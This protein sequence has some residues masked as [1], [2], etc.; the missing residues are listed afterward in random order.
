MSGRNA[1]RLSLPDSLQTKL[2]QFRRHVWTHKSIEAISIAVFVVFTVFLSVYFLD[3]VVDTPRQLRGALLLLA[4]LGCCIVPWSIYRWIWKCQRLDQLAMLL[5]HEHPS[6]GDQLLG[7]I[8]LVDNEQEQARSR[9]LCEAAVVQVAEQ[10]EARDLTN[11]VP[12]PRHKLLSKLAGGCMLAALVLLAVSPAATTNAWSRYLLPWRDTPR[13][14]FTVIDPQENERT[15]PHGENFRF[16]IRLADESRWRPGAAAVRIGGGEPIEER[17]SGDTYHFDCP[18]Q[19]TGS[20]LTLSV[21]D[22]SQQLSLIPTMRPELTSVDAE[23]QLPRYLQRAE[24]LSK[25]MRSGVGTFVA[26]S[27]AKIAAVASRKLDAATVNGGAVSLADDGFQSD[28]IPIEGETRLSLE[29]RDNLGLDGQ[30]PFEL[31]LMSRDD[32]APSI[33]CEGLARQ[34]VVLDTETLSFQVR[35]MDD[36]GIQHV[37]FEWKGI[38]TAMASSPARGEK[39]LGAGS[40]TSEELHLTGTFSARTLGIQP[41]PIEIRLFAEDYLPQ[42]ERV[43]TPVYT[44]YVLAPADHAIWLTDQLSKWHRHSLEVRDRELQLYEKNKQLRDLDTAELDRAATRREIERQAAAERTNGRRLNRLTSIGEDLVKQASRNKEFGVG[45]LETWA[46]MLQ[47]LK[48]ISAHRMPSVAEL[49]RNAANAE[50]IAANGN[51]TANESAPAVG[52]S[53]TSGGNGDGPEN[54]GSPKKP[55][56]PTIVD[57]ESSQQP[58]DVNGDRTEPS[59]GQTGS[60]RLTLPVTT[61]AGKTSN[62]DACPVSQKMNHAVTE[63]RELLNEFEKVADELNKILANLE[64]STL[65]KRLKAVSRTEYR[66]AGQLGDTVPNAFGLNG[67]KNNDVRELLVNLSKEQTDTIQTIS[68]IMDDMQ[69]YYERRRKA[70]FKTI[71]AEMEGTDVLGAL[72]DV[73]DDMEAESGVTIAQCEFWSDTFDRWAEDLV[74]PSDGGT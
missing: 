56:I 37:G 33:V 42:R 18:A 52:Q 32:E 15:V 61:L 70:T 66:I 3:R 72:R 36:F 26:G 28:W 21:G 39:L 9:E 50:R 60:D 54:D 5:R 59:Q 10:A 2:R 1:V 38:D 62:R 27:R 8:E 67:L 20:T 63:Q 41:Q 30:K 55:T 7:I 48:D 40:P 25:D 71:L 57:S 49:L 11:A 29:W 6:I 12:Y 73:T 64:G 35:S 46:E 31:S 23:I 74:D 45:H 68:Y 4:M 14:T 34:R 58:R 43:Y 17:L 13:Y 44:L 53:R 69:A 24:H 16:A 22:F 19:M 47:T 65:V 51:P